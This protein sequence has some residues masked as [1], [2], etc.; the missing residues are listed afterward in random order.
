MG[1]ATLNLDARVGDGANCKVRF[2][3]R[4]D[5]VLSAYSLKREKEK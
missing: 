5:L 1:M 4:V 2:L 3:I